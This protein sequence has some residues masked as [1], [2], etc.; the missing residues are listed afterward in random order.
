M[1]ASLPRTIAE[2]AR[3]IEARSLSPVELTRALLLR[4]E[5]IEPLIAS[6]IT[7]TAESA[8]EQARRAESELAILCGAAP[9]L[10]EMLARVRPAGGSAEPASVFRFRSP[11]EA[12]AAGSGKP[13]RI[14]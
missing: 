7:V 9:H 4:I 10:I 12:G 3:L 6:F 13:G 8:L 2:A 14:E 1:P 11:V 5:T